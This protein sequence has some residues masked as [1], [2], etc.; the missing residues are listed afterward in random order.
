[1]I[2]RRSFISRTTAGFIGYSATPHPTL[3]ADR[4]DLLALAAAHVR[5]AEADR[6]RS[7]LWGRLGGSSTERA[8]SRLFEKQIKPYVRSTELEGFEFSAFRPVRWKLWSQRLSE[9]L[10]SAMPTPFD[11]RFPSDVVRAPLHPIRSDSDWKEADGRFVFVEATMQGSVY[12]NSVRDD[13][14]YKRAVASGA[15][16]MIFSLPLKPGSWRAVA[17]I[18]RAYAVRDE[19]YPDKRRPIPCF[20]VDAFDGAFLAA[21]RG[22][23]LA[24]NIEYEPATK[25]EALN[26]VGH[27]P[28]LNRAR[29]AVFNHLDSFFSGA[30]DN[31]SGLATTIGLAYRL[32]RL[33]VEK[34]FAD[35]FFVALAAHHDGAEGMRA[36]AERDPNR[37]SRL[38]QAI[39]IEHTDAQSGREGNEAGWPPNLNNL[40]QAY[41]GNKGWP[42]VR[43]ALP[44]L[45]KDSGVMSVS[46]QTVDACIGDLLAICDRQ[47]SFSLIQAPPYY[48]TDHDTIDKISRAGL[49]AAVDFHMRLLQVTGAVA[50]G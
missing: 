4:P 22:E 24:A 45:V 34:R 40:R 3:A 2:S 23:E 8:S 20:C 48:H 10:A 19:S 44:E 32:S 12:R 27:L 9:G 41:L 30:N 36:F 33:P 16:G 14:L 13:G 15:V 37:F 7:A 50:R 1:M 39:L 18:D 49:E 46:P 35:F 11:A 6:G 29:V 43:E 17:P 31:A 21:L 38:S 47:K 42:E 26:V 28:G 25:R 5:L